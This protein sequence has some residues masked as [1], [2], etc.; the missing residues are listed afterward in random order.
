MLALNQQAWRPGALVV[1]VQVKITCVEDRTGGKGVKNRP[2][3]S[4][5]S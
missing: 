4:K 1:T 5:G 3:C 2:W